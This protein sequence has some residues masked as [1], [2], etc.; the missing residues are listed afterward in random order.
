[1]IPRD[2]MRGKNSL[3]GKAQLSQW[4]MLSY[5][6]YSNGGCSGFW[7]DSLLGQTGKW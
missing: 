7:P 3:L 4:H 1:M 5:V 2:P 6:K